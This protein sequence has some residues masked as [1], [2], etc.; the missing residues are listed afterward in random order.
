MSS[1]TLRQNGTEDDEFDDF[2]L[3]ESLTNISFQETM[4]CRAVDDGL[5]GRMQSIFEL[6]T[7]C[8]VILKHKIGQGFYGEVYLGIMEKEDNATSPVQVA[9]K[10]LKNLGDTELRD[11]NDFQREIDIMKVQTNT[12][13]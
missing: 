2:V 9:V 11:I 7:N 12:L 6:G 5:F 1:S 13:K 10:K 8:N 4:K 3:S